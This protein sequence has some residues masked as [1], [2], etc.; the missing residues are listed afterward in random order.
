MFEG[1]DEDTA[2]CIDYVTAGL[3]NEGLPVVVVHPFAGKIGKLLSL[4][5]KR[6][7]NDLEDGARLMIYEG[8]HRQ[9]VSTEIRPALTKGQIVLCEHDMSMF[10]TREY[11]VRKRLDLIKPYFELLDGYARGA[12]WNER[13]ELHGGVV[14]SAIFLDHYP[15]LGERSEDQ[16]RERHAYMEAMHY[17]SNS[18]N[19]R[20]RS[21]P[22]HAKLALEFVLNAIR[23]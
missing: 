6:Y 3:Q 21:N 2:S 1:R 23:Q 22:N 16:E 15:P 11:I 4:M 13:W 14:P 19:I 9:F 5:A 12:R 8:I 10:I 17:F 18:I 7:A 20:A